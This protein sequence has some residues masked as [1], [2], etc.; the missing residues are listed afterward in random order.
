LTVTYKYLINFNFIELVIDDKDINVRSYANS[1][2][3]IDHLRTAR[4]LRWEGSARGEIGTMVVSYFSRVH[5]QKVRRAWRTVVCVLWDFGGATVHPGGSHGVA[6]HS[7]RRDSS[8]VLYVY[9]CDS[10]QRHASI[11]HLHSRS[12]CMRAR[13]EGNNKNGYVSHLARRTC[14]SPVRRN[15]REKREDGRNRVL[16]E[17]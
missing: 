15:Q 10:F 5:E 8:S 2:K 17:K 7:H 13:G 3:S 6:L 4:D 12:A 9:V 1:A 11:V 14:Y 16:P